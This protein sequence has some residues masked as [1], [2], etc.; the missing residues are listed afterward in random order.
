MRITTTIIIIA[1]AILTFQT[2]IAKEKKEKKKKKGEVAMMTE[3]TIPAIDSNK[4]DK[5]G[6][7][8]IKELTKKCSKI[9]GLFNVYQDSASGKLY[10]EITED[11]LGKEA[12][13]VL[14]EG[15]KKE[16]DKAKEKL[17]NW[18]PFKKKDK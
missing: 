13:K 17:K 10:I 8:P 12:G 18:D 1:I 14:G 3:D 16:V 9:S 5:E 4:I 7:K 11:K 2:T 6:F 15:G